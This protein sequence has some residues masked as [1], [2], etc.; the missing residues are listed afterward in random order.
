[1][2]SDDDEPVAKLDELPENF[3]A[4]FDLEE[5]PE[6]PDLQ[7][8][9][10]VEELRKQAEQKYAAQQPARKAAHVLDDDGVDGAKDQPNG[11][12]WKKGAKAKED[13]P[14]RV[15]PKIDE[16]R[17][18]FFSNT[19]H[20]YELIPVIRLLGPK[21]FPALIELSKTF[22]AQGKGHEVRESMRDVRSS[23]S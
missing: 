22:K 10:N 2:F 15:I 13:K 7:P 12:S 19:S 1:M 17:S 3:D 9:L 16:E 6:F 23:Y 14:K 8:A 18:G 21:G 20:V 5:D 4:L 11:N